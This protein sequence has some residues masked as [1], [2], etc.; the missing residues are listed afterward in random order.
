M[1]DPKTPTTKAQLDALDLDWRDQMAKDWAERNPELAAG[2]HQ[3]QQAQRSKMVQI[4]EDMFD[5]NI[6]TRERQL[7][8]MRE[9]AKDLLAKGKAHGDPDALKT[10]TQRMKSIDALEAQLARAVGTMPPT[11]RTLDPRMG[12]KYAGLDPETIKEAAGRI[13]GSLQ[14]PS[15]RRVPTGHAETVRWF[16]DVVG[17]TPQEFE[18]FKDSIKDPNF[19]KAFK[20]NYIKLGLESPHPTTQARLAKEA[21]RTRGQTLPYGKG[22]VPAL[23]AAGLGLLVTCLLYTSPS[24]RD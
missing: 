4:Q 23:G 15:A 5:M 1:A 2:E 17:W 11:A 21:A 16:K 9:S 14:H 3:G 12:K 6:R 18:I 24:P 20:D 8:R 22:A 10:F 19:V 7:V 13:R